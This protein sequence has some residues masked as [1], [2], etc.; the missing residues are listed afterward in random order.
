VARMFPGLRE[1][2]VTTSVTPYWALVC[3]CQVCW[4]IALAQEFILAALLFTL[5]I[6]GGLAGSAWVADARDMTVKDYWLLR[7]PF[8]LHLGWI[9]CT[10]AVNANVLAN[11]YEAE[12]GVL[13]ALA[14]VLLAAITVAVAL[15]ATAVRNPDCSPSLVA[16][17]AFLAENAERQPAK[18]LQDPNRFKLHTW[19]D[20]PLQGV[21]GAVRVLSICSLV[22]FSLALYLRWA[23]TH[24]KQPQ[25]VAMHAV[26]VE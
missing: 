23:A 14:V 4:T 2:Y 10:S 3:L 17:W 26:P 1:S 21:R 19:D 22:F 5:G 18:N 15:Y 13:L 16:A 8:S 11:F 7:A 12:P 6:L 24:G 25:P 20:V 9:I